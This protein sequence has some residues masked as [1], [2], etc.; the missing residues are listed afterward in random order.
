MQWVQTESSL[1]WQQF[2][3]EVAGHLDSDRATVVDSPE[4]APHLGFGDELPQLHTL[5]HA[6]YLHNTAM[7]M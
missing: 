1:C 5:Q 6:G 7:S 2:T 3:E 4:E